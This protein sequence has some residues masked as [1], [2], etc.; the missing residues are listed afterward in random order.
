MRSP[1]QV[2]VVPFRIIK[3]S[4]DPEFLVLKRADLDV[5][6]AGVAGGGEDGESPAGA[7]ERESVEELGLEHT[8]AVYPL[9]SVASVPV[10][11][12]SDRASWPSGLYTIPEYAFMIDLTGERISLSSEHTSS[13]WLGYDGALELLCWDSNR[14]AIW[15]ARQRLVRM[16]LPASSRRL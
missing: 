16:D 9:Q 1:F 10:Y 6:Q 5:W 7:A 3:S 2:L 14:T 12:F 15:E 13:R 4:G 11:H 8:V